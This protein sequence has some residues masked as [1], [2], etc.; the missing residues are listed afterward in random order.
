M[1]KG[2]TLTHSY[3][4]RWVIDDPIRDK[5]DINKILKIIANKPQELL[6]FTMGINCGLLLEDLLQIKVKDVRYLGISQ[7][8]Q[9]K[10]QRTRYNNIFKVNKPIRKALDN[11]LSSGEYKE[12]NHFLFKTRGRENCPLSVQSAEKL[13]K[14][15]TKAILLNGN[16]GPETLRKT[17]GYQQWIA[18]GMEFDSMTKCF[19]HS[20]FKTTLNYIGAK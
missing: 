19:R 10:E 13:I 8:H 9:V 2:P 15:W 4:S 6:L 18:N 5:N 7:I 14:K 11:Y 3:K 17:W 16:F 12:D 20:D 1:E